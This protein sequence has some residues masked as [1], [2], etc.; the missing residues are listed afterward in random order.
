MKIVIV[1][2]T[3]MSGPTVCVGGIVVNTGMPVRLM[4]PDGRKYPSV[5]TPFDIGQLWELD[6]QNVP[7]VQPPHVEDIAIQKRTLIGNQPDFRS[8]LLD[9]LKVSIWKG[10]PS[11]LFDGYL[12][13]TGRGRGFISRQPMMPQNSTGFWISDR[14]LNLVQDDSGRLYYKYSADR[15]IPYV[16]LEDTLPCIKG[17]TLIRVSLARWW[18]PEDVE[19][20][21]RCYLQLSGWY[22]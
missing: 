20:E 13:F 15:E 9:T 19:I 1:S 22:L 18:K 12:Q 6:F 17:G 2:K 5:K 7:G 21:E 10:G 16:G 3:R 8:Y 4:G 14:D 11:D